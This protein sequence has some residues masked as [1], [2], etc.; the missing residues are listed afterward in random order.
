ML[1]VSSLTGTALAGGPV[2]RIIF[3]H[4]TGPIDNTTKAP[5][6]YVS[7]TPSTRGAMRNF[8]FYD[9][10][11]SNKMLILLANQSFKQAFFA[12]VMDKE[13]TCH[14]FFCFTILHKEADVKFLSAVFV[15]VGVQIWLHTFLAC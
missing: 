11:K 8:R 14:K 5:L 9:L 7:V 12:G 2:R 15:S 10:K 4:S 6:L 1:K 3:R 13:R